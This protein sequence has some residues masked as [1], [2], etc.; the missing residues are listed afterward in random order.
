MSCLPVTLSVLTV[1]M[2]KALNYL[3]VTGMRDCACIFLCFWMKQHIIMLQYAKSKSWPHDNIRLKFRDHYTMVYF[4]QNVLTTCTH[5]DGNPSNNFF[6]WSHWVNQMWTSKF[7]CRKSQGNTMCKHCTDFV[8][9]WICWSAGAQRDDRSSPN[10][11]GTLLHIESSY[12]QCQEKNIAF[13]WF[14]MFTILCKSLEPPLNS[15]YFVSNDP[16]RLVISLT[17]HTFF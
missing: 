11:E 2:S 17:S 4:V 13:N 8:N 14:D 10:T 1:Q 7:P 15:L 12:L 3:A 16:D 5:S 6:G 9:K